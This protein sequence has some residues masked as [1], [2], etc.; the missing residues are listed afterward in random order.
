MKSSVT[1][2]VAPDR[3]T[4]TPVAVYAGVSMLPKW[5]ALVS[6]ADSTT[7]TL[8][9]M[10]T[11]SPTAVQPGGTNV[12]RFGSCE[13]WLVAAIWLDQADAMLESL[14]STASGA[15]PRLARRALMDAANAAASDK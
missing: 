15:K 11:F 8:G 4:P 9:P 3:T 6:N 7:A 12:A 5:N 14:T 13:S 10:P 2:M 1:Q